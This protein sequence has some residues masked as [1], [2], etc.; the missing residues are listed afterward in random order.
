M[1]WKPSKPPGTTML[2]AL[3]QEQVWQLCQQRREIPWMPVRKRTRPEFVSSPGS[4]PCHI[5]HLPCTD[6]TASCLLFTA[7]VPPESDIVPRKQHYQIIHPTNDHDDDRLVYSPAVK[8]DMNSILLS[9]VTR[10][11]DLYSQQEKNKGPV[12]QIYCLQWS[13]FFEIPKWSS[14]RPVAHSAH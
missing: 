5:H 10:C 4:P 8:Y 6:K 2:Q 7:I 11:S 13:V 14:Y 1:P 12:A 9:I 3:K